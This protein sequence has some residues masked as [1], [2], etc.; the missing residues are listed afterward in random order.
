MWPPFFT[1]APSHVWSPFITQAPSSANCLDCI[2]PYPKG[3]GRVGMYVPKCVFP[4]KWR[5]ITYQGC[6]AADSDQPWCATM[7]TASREPIASM[8]CFV[9]PLHDPAP[10]RPS[11][12]LSPGRHTPICLFPFAWRDTIHRQC[13]TQDRAVPWCATMLSYS[14]EPLHS[15]YCT[16]PLQVPQPSVQPPIMSGGEA[17][18]HC[19]PSFRYK[20]IEYSGCTAADREV[21]WCAVEVNE[22]KEPVASIYCSY[23]HEFDPYPNQSP[24]GA[25]IAAVGLDAC[26]F[27]FVWREHEYRECIAMDAEAPWCP[28][29]LTE[30]RWPSSSAYCKVTV[31]FEACILPFVYK[32]VSYH[33]CTRM[34]A[35]APWCATS[36]NAKGFVK[37]VSLLH[38][39]FTQITHRH[40]LVTEDDNKMQCTFPFYY[41]G[42]IY[43]QCTAVHSSFAW[44]A[45]KTNQHHEPMM[46]AACT[47]DGATMTL[48]NGPCVFP[49]KYKGREYHQCACE[50]AE[51]CWCPTAL[52]DTGEPAVSD[53]CRDTLP[54]APPLKP[55]PS[56]GE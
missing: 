54:A 40:S 52:T 35:H 25:R 24:P 12:R 19:V 37:K 20:D 55:P 46:I 47:K 48:H 41:N 33:T 43:N 29:R 7:V 30:T 26:K 10:S 27:P 53:Y 45:V 21:P 1:P 34:D 44:C 16:D 17:S 51:A 39:I 15:I 14:H 22:E 18:L 31:D 4:F 23:N 50:D 28:T 42:K 13:T 56:R 38:W 5:N 11:P 49:F 9:D 36:V 8:Y 2:P 32:G 3:P 6:T